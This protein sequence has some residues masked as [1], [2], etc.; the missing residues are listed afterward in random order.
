MV[1]LLIVDRTLKAERKVEPHVVVASEPTTFDKDMWL[2]IDKNHGTLSTL[3]E[4]GLMQRNTVV[5]VDK[6]MHI[7]IEPIEL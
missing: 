2:L 3:G 1:R 4:A 6:S 5:T 7:K